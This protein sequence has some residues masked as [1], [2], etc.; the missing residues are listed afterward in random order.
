MSSCIISTDKGQ[1]F[2]DITD[3]GNKVWIAGP[4]VYSDLFML[5]WYTIT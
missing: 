5:Q 3:T 1:S 4:I 2:I